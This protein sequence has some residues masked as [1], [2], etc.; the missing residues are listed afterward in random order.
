MQTIDDGRAERLGPWVGAMALAD[1]VLITGTTLVLE[2]INGRRHDLPFSIDE[3]ALRELLDP[4]QAAQ[5][6]RTISNHYAGLTPSPA[7]DGMDEFWRIS[8]MAKVV[9]ETIGRYHPA[10]VERSA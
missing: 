3:V 9:A 4:R 10:T 5:L 2:E 6:A 1:Q 7:P 8:N